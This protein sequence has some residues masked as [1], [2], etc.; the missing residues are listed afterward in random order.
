MVVDHKEHPPGR[1]AKRIDNRKSNLRFATVGQNRMNACLR[2]D[3]TS[4]HVGV[5][6]KG[7]RWEANIRHKGKWYTKR[8]PHTDEGFKAACAWREEMEQKL[9]GDFQY[10]GS[11][12]QAPLPDAP[13]QPAQGAGQG[14]KEWAI[15][16]YKTNS[17]W[18]ASIQRK[19]VSYKKR[20]PLTDEGFKD[21]RAWREETRK[22]LE[23]GQTPD[24]PPSGK[25]YSRELPKGVSKNTGRYYAHIMR[26]GKLY[27]KSFPGTDEGLREAVEWR[28]GMEEKLK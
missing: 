11:T 9:F 1:L 26:K 20:F 25:K 15:G 13:V 17:A 22:A 3:N 18:V 10:S 21:A 2:R 12:M 28:K 7:R 8:F 4:G 24:E 23:S 5:Q 27:S 16:V 19:R 14:P 6:N